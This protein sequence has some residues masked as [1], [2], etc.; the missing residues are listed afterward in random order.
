[1]E[2]PVPPLGAPAADLDLFPA[3]QS[4]E[5]AVRAWWAR[6]ASVGLH[7]AVVTVLFF[8]PLG[9][10]PTRDVRLFVAQ[11]REPIHLVAPPLQDLTQKAPNRGKVGKEFD[12]ESLLPRPRIFVPPSAPP[13][14]PPSGRPLSLP[15]PPKIDAGQSAALVLPPPVIQAQEAPSLVLQYPSAARSPD[16]A[17]PQGTGK[18]TI[19][20]PSASVAELNR[21]IAKGKGAGG[22]VIE[23]IPPGLGGDG[24][25]LDIAPSPS[26]VGS[27]LELLSDPKGVDFR[28]YLIRVLTAVKR[29]WQAVIPE[30]AKRGRSGR[31][32][33][34]F[35]V[36]RDGSIPKLVIASASGTEA[37]DRA[38]VAG[39]SA[40]NPFPPLPPEFS[41]DSIRLQLVFLYNMRP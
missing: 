30:S 1:M 4:Q 25:G 34:Q 37:L 15:E 3:W 26:G 29:N 17:K 11:L 40:T 23:D 41:G 8:T 7:L 22:L 33:I 16:T 31:T 28:P 5:S 10:G 24:V 20:S 18:L 9:R 32:V 36:A 14:A 39:I 27:R 6:A 12:L 19:P 21:S 13:G 35:A 2:T 38:A